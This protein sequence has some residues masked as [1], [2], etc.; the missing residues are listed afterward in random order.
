MN[1]FADTSALIKKYIK[2]AGSEKVVD[3]F[4]SFLYVGT[5][6]LTQAEMASA[7]AK[8]AR[9]GWVD[10]AEISLAWQVFQ[11]H[12]P[13]YIRLPVT[14]AVIA[15]ATALSWRRGLRA[16]DA[17]HLACALNWKGITGDEVVFACFDKALLRA[18]RQEGLE[19]WPEGDLAG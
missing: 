12:W 15:Q 7:M 6:A 19:I 4:D 14:S 17:V 13:G 18:A 10:E 3:Y 9:L 8:A 2:E 5:A 1:L 16:S 11:T